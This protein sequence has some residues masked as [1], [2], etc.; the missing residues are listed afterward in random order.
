MNN[1]KEKIIRGLK[2]L[3]LRIFFILLG[4]LFDLK[5]VLVKVE[6]MKCEGKGWWLLIRFLRLSVV[7]EYLVYYF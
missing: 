1:K 3:G 5:E 2:F 4:R 6:V 7:I